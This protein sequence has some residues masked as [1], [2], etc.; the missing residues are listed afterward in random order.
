MRVGPDSQA[1][2]SSPAGFVSRSYYRRAALLGALTW[3]VL[4]VTF[5][6]FC[7]D[8]MFKNMWNDA[9]GSELPALIAFMILTMPAGIVAP[10]LFESPN[11]AVFLA[12]YALNGALWGLAVAFV[13]KKLRTLK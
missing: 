2:G 7:L 3:W 9:A 4:G 11:W 10:V 1:G 8:W 6:D 12:V 5:G 13:V